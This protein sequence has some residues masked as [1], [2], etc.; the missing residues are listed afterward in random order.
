VPL[1]AEQSFISSVQAINADPKL[2]R[3]QCV[4]EFTLAPP[5]PAAGQTGAV[6]QRTAVF[7]DPPLG[8]SLS[9]PGIAAIERRLN[10]Q[11]DHP[12][13]SRID[14]SRQL[15]WCRWCRLLNTTLCIPTLEYLIGRIV[16]TPEINP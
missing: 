6:K 11:A 1:L 10:E 12:A 5:Q 3:S 15:R 14:S 7:D 8:S 9:K 4:V 13:D 16:P 2:A